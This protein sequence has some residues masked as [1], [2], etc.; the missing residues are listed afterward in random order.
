MLSLLCDIFV[1]MVLIYIL[2]LIYYYRN[3][4]FSN[5]ES[6]TTLNPKHLEE[7]SCIKSNHKTNNNIQLYT[8][9]KNPPPSNMFN[10]NDFYITKHT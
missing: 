2:S 7:T 1:L 4:I 10:N 8:T 3:D 9:Y 5:F 6:F